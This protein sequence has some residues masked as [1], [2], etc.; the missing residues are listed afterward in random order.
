[1]NMYLEA[2]YGIEIGEDGERERESI[3]KLPPQMVDRMR[4]S[5][6]KFFIKKNQ[7]ASSGYK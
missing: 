6:L 1:M 5:N 7:R 4:E 2:F 3:E